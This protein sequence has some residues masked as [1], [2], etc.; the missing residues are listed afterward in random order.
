MKVEN[1][2]C[3]G[4]GYVGGPTMS[5]IADQ[6]P[7]LRVTVCDIDADRIAQWNSDRLPVYE[8]GLEEGVRRTRGRN[9]F[10][11]VLS[12]EAIAQADLIFVS[13]N[14]PT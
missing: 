8:P 7:G 11:Q 2:L 4:A 1:I 14:P 5:V 3:M 10:F 6:C 13:V 9:L 12:P